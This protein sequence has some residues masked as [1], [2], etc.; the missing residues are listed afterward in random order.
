MSEKLEIVILGHIPNK[1]LVK[2]L[3]KW[4]SNLFDLTVTSVISNLPNPSHDLEFLNPSYEDKQL[5]EILKE[6][7]A[8][9]RIGII[10]ADLEDNFYV[11]RISNKTAVIS[12]KS[13]QPYLIA[14]NITTENFLKRTIYMVYTL[15]L[16]T[17]GQFTIDAYQIPHIETRGCLFD[18]NG[19]LMDVIYN[20]EQPIICDSCV[21][22]LSG[23]NLPQDYIKNL[24]RELFKIR[25]SRLER[26]ET[27]IK[28]QPL[29]SFLLTLLMGII[30]NLIANFIYDQITYHKSNK[31]DTQIQK[32][33]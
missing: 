23:K 18:L 21:A 17:Q 3:C 26:I 13:S 1:G 31:T 11:R 22:R 20:T 29:L 19:A 24:K 10:F 14:S 8:N 25:K 32:Q 4:E 30:L 5:K 6:D 12:I 7:T 9:L 2:R 15:Y 33:K 16:E 28:C 27:F